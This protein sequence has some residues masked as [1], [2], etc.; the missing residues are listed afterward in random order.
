MSWLVIDASVAA[1]WLFP[2][3]PQWHDALLLRERIVNGQVQ[4]A[5]PDLFWPEV[6]NML[7]KAVARRRIAAAKA[8]RDLANLRLVGVLTISTAHLCETALD[9]GTAYAHPTYDLI[10]AALARQ[11]HG[12]VVTADER[13]IQAVGSSLPVRRLGTV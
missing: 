8:T 6:T 7:R 11:L 13:F 4:A 12:E 9:W 2:E 1:K 5:V 3:E 10:Y